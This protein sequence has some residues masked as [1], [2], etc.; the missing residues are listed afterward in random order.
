MRESFERWLA[1]WKLNRFRFFVF[2]LED[3][4]TKRKSVDWTFSHNSLFNILFLFSFKDFILGAT[5]PEAAG[6]CN[7]CALNSTR[8]EKSTICWHCWHS[9]ANVSRMILNQTHPI[10]RQCTSRSKFHVQQQCWRDFC[11][12]LTSTKFTLHF[13]RSFQDSV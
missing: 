4:F 5:Q 3:N 10:R 1:L 2:R 6:S 13:S 11:G 9:S 12:S 7:R 8:M